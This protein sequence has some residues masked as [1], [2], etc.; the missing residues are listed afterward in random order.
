[1]RV[2]CRKIRPRGLG[3]PG[4]SG[5]PH[6]SRRAQKKHGR[7]PKTEMNLWDCGILLLAG[8]KR[9]GQKRR[10]YKIGP[11]KHVHLHRS[12]KQDSDACSAPMDWRGGWRLTRHLFKRL[13][14][15]ANRGEKIAAGKVESIL[16]PW[17]EALVFL[18]AG[19]AGENFAGRF[20]SEKLQAVQPANSAS[21]RRG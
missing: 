13:R 2:I 1:M 15:P 14:D 19:V 17:E 10:N 18:A 9:L 16:L 11:K 8:L 6:Q 21:A 20:K 4:R 3:F 5:L 7:P 12:R